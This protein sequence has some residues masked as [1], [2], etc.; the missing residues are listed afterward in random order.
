MNCKKQPTQK[1][2]SAMKVF[3]YASFNDEG[4]RTHLV[5]TAETSFESLPG[6]IQEIYKK[7]KV[8]EYDVNPD[9]LSSHWWLCKELVDNLRTKGWEACVWARVNSCA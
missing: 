8:K 6:N 1:Q 9:D 4:N 2:G 5:R 3:F 7:I